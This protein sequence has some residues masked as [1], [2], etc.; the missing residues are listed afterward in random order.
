MNLLT[1][2]TLRN[3]LGLFCWLVACSINCVPVAA[4][5]P[6]LRSLAASPLLDK[7]LPFQQRS[8]S[9]SKKT[10]DRTCL[11]PSAQV[12]YDYLAENQQLPS[13]ARTPKNF[14]FHGWKW[15]TQSLIRQATQLSRAAAFWGAEL[16]DLSALHTSVQHVV[17]LN[18]QGL[19]RIE[20]R[21]FFPWVQERVGRDLPQE[22]ARALGRVLK[23]LESTQRTMQSLG[24][25]LV[26]LLAPQQELHS[27]L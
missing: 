21:V 6:Q 22:T 12:L 5:V 18:L 8:G 26:C 20:N 14:Y 27:S 16:W 17:Q 7:V 25:E 1:M 11:S 3:A 15:H 19:H 2:A 13:T 4:G 10:I 9:Q 23:E 24:K